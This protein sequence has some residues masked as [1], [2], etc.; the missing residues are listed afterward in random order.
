MFSSLL[1]K[2]LKLLLKL[3]YENN[4]NITLILLYASVETSY[5]RTTTRNGKKPN[6]KN[7]INKQKSVIRVFKKIAELNEFNLISI[8]TENKTPEQVFKEFKERTNN[9]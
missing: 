6:I 1:N 9:G 5:K 3:K 7:I 2:P 8:N 4:I